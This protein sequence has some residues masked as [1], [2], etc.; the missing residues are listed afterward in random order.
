VM[1]REHLTQSRIRWARTGAV[2]CGAIVGTAGLFLYAYSHSEVGGY[3]IHDF[4]LVGSTAPLEVRSLDDLN[5]DGRGDL[6]VH[7]ILGH[8]SQIYFGSSPS[9]R[10]SPDV[11][12]TSDALGH[13]SGGSVGD[14]DGDGLADLVVNILLGEPEGF[15]ATGSSYLIK[16]R[17][18]WPQTLQLPRDADSEFYVPLRKDIRLV[19]CTSP[20]GVDL[21]SD[22]LRDILLGG[23]DYSPPGRSSAGGAFVLFGRRDWPARL[24]VIAAADVTIHGSRTGEALRPQC[25]AGDFTGDGLPD[26]ALAATEDTLW[27]LQGGRGRV[28]VFA[29]APAWPRLIDAERENETRCCNF[30][31]ARRVPSWPRRC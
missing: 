27:F 3:P 20:R 10:T 6:V 24:D 15:T 30:E 31:A 29:G 12:I 14:V 1:R 21:N 11:R 23:A 16:G 2:L 19:A 4:A 28:Y 7:V 5:G 22:G 9:T 8:E 18:H 13:P 26:L 25:S 17:R